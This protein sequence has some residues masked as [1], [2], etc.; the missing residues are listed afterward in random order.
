MR[1][2]EAVFTVRVE[3]RGN[4]SELVIKRILLLNQGDRLLVD[5]EDKPGIVE[6]KSVNPGEIQF[7]IGETSHSVELKHAEVSRVF[8]EHGL[9]EIFGESPLMFLISPSADINTTIE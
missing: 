1:L 9:A 3:Q 2:S 4:V 5:R 8:A 6:F 7:V